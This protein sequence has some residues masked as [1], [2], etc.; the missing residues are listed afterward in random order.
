[1]VGETDGNG[2]GGRLDDVET[3]VLSF[4]PRPEHVALA[5]MLAAAVASRH[6]LE[7]EAVEDIRLL[8]SEA[9][10]NAVRAHSRGN[11]DAPIQL[12]CRTDGAFHLEVCDSGGG[13]DIA[14]T[15]RELPDALSGEGDGGYGIPIIRI[16]AQDSA[17][18]TNT[19][20]GTTV[21]LSVSSSTRVVIEAD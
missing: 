17:F 12:V 1:M 20:G 13:F 8:V 21:R 18:E 5:R 19:E 14:S 15:R 10:T 7:P 11:V 2:N 3:V 16:L 6:G 9:C 4:P